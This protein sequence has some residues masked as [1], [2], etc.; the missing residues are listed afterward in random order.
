MLK[1]GLTGGIG[2]GKT[3][4]AD[5]LA[6]LGAAIIDTDVISH[7]LTAAGGAAMADIEL[8]FGSAVIA[9]NG[10]LNRGLMREM[11]FN[12]PNIREQL[13]EI[14]HPLIFHET[15][16]QAMTCQ[17]DYLLLV[18]PLLIESGR[19]QDRVDK[20]CVVDC[21]PET[22]IQRV[23]K[24]NNLSVEQVQRIMSAQATRN[25]RL[26]HA[27]YVVLNGHKT[28]LDNLKQQCLELHQHLCELLD[29]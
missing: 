29:D 13:Q 1:I 2:S 10:S 23:I 16:R 7:E 20:I 19:W 15:L 26:E 25:Q 3:M 12:Q 11:V 9:E 27:D 8:A 22:Q 14:L 6:D 4:V 5:Y 17:G 28:T 21:E 24:R 18:V